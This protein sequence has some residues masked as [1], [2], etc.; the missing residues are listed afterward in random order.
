MS[1]SP[2][3]IIKPSRLPLL[4][5]YRHNLIVIITLPGLT[6]FLFIIPQELK[7]AENANKA[8]RYCQEEQN[9]IRYEEDLEQ[10]QVVSLV[11]SYNVMAVMMMMMMIIVMIMMMIIFL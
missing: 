7:I 10:P 6:T 11:D 9:S 3:D 1:T 4:S 5:D 2:L 8:G